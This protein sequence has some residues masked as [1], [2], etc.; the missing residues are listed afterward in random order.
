MFDVHAV[1]TTVV[2]VVLDESLLVNVSALGVSAAAL[3]FL[4]R[5]PAGLPASSGW[6][7]SSSGMTVG[8]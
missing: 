1:V 8:W 3:S 6:T 4:S 7:G 5:F 2:E